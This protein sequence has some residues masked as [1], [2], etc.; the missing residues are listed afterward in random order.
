M[1]PQEWPFPRKFI[2]GPLPVLKF[3]TPITTSVSRALFTL[4]IDQNKR[5]KFLE[6]NSC[7]P[8]GTSKCFHHSL[9]YTHCCTMTDLNLNW[10]H[11]QNLSSINRTE[12]WKTYI[13]P[14]ICVSQTIP[15]RRI[16]VHLYTWTYMRLSKCFR[17]SPPGLLLF[18][19]FWGTY[20]RPT[21][22]CVT[23]MSGFLN[24]FWWSSVFCQYLT[25]FSLKKYCSN[26]LC[27]FLRI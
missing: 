1:A 24:C 21:Y 11:Q 17:Y 25:F 26:K 14:C 3:F 15:E 13:R 22:K 6:L 20:I 23:Y 16:Y 5:F 18:I 8:D 19:L 27:I 9:Q 4:K 12:S 10:Q 2:L 7:P